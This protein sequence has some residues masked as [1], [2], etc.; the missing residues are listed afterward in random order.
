[1][2]KKYLKYKFKIYKIF[3][4]RFIDADFNFFKKKFT[5]GIFLVFPAAPAIVN[6][7]RDKGYYQ[8]IK[9]ADYA[10]FDSGYLCLLLKYFKSIKVKKFSG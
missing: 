9:N 10:L 6:I 4:I 8:S 7:Y 1:M 5:K 3:K 2:K